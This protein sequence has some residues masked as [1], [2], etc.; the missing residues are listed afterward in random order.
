MKY[1]IKFNSILPFKGF[2]ALNL[3][4][5]ILIRKDGWETLSDSQKQ[6]TLHHEAI[7]TAQGRELLWIGFYIAYLFEWFIRLFINGKHAYD[8]ISF[9]REAYKYEGDLNYKRKHFA[10][11]R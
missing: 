3:F 9:E 5:L 8:K 4:G 10:Q 7:H 6:V 2:V 1:T 11:W